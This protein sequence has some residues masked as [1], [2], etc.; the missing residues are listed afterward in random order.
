MKI[1][2]IQFEI[3]WANPTENIIRADAAI[4]R[5]PGSDLYIMPEMF[6]TGFIMKPKGL[7]ESKDSDS[8]KWMIRK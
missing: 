1:T 4:N 7:A 8:L 5:S 3:A 6:T 2:L